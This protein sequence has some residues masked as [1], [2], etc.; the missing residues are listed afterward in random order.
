MKFWPIPN[1]NIWS[2]LSSISNIHTAKL[3]MWCFILKQKGLIFQI[4]KWLIFFLFRQK[5]KK[6]ML[7]VPLEVP[8]SGASNESPHH[9]F[10]WRNV[11]KLS[12]G[13][14][15]TINFQISLCICKSGQAIHYTLQL[16]ITRKKR[17]TILLR[18]HMSDLFV[19]R[20]YAPVNP[21]GSCLTLSVYI[22]TLLLGR[23]SRLSG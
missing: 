14:M 9:M 19:L 23:L 22:T 8:Q 18:Y 16:G 15:W 7:W 13:Y 5:K 10:S 20:F 21:M 1:I 3:K 12:A 17:I 4:Q 2:P 11:Q 6:Y